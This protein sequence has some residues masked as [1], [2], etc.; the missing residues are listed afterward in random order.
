MTTET[1]LLSANED[2]ID[3]GVKLLDENK[4]WT[5]FYKFKGSELNEAKQSTFVILHCM[6]ESSPYP[7]ICVQIWYQTYGMNVY[8]KSKSIAM[9]YND[10]KTH[11]LAIVKQDNVFYVYLDATLNKFEIF[12]IKYGIDK[13]LVLGAY[14]DVEGNYGRYWNGT[15]YE[16]RVF[17]RALAVEEVESFIYSNPAM[18]SN[19]TLENNPVAML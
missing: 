4:D 5:V 12:D 14:T 19:D 6:E 11:C 16:C 13:T 3:T 7:G 18:T 9:S 17:N 1:Q 8:D 10:T 2:Y 15:V